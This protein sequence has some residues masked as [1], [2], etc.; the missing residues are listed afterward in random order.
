[1]QRTVLS[2]RLT[3]IAIAVI[4]YAGMN[5]CHEIVGH[6]GMAA[7]L[8]TKCQLISS[9][10][11]P[12]ITQPP[13]WKYNIIV[14]S[15]SAAN[16]TIGLVCLGLLRTLRT[17]PT[18]RYFL[19][20]SMSVNLFLPSTYMTAAPIIKFGDSYILI[21]DLPGQMFWRVALVLVG[22]A[23]CWFSF[24]LCRA[25]LGRLIGFGGRA[26][27]SIAWELV[28]PAYIA[29][30][31]ITVTSGLFSQLEFKVAQFEAAGGTFGL[32]AWLLLLPLVIPEAPESVEQPFKVSRSRW[33]IVAGALVALIFIGVLGPGI[34]L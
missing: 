31:V 33:W 4:A 6:C 11:I 12:L 7:L 18:L 13:T 24:R 21:R 2:D 17:T 16:W 10:N 3:V 34:S 15:G 22:G 1:M 8:G 5:I 30:G 32:T 19:W 14:I 29:G 27:R 9:T 23:I 25:E 26:A 28:A 20:L